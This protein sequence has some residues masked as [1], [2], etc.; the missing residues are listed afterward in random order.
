MTDAAQPDLIKIGSIGAPHALSG[1]VRVRTIDDP[2][3]LLGIK[4]VQIATRGWLTVKAWENHTAGLIVRLVGVTTKEA[5]DALRDLEI[6]ADR[7]ELRLEP[8]RFFYHDLIG[9]PVRT[10]DGSELGRVDDV[11]DSGAHDLLSIAVDGQNHLVPLQAPYVHV[12]EGFVEL[13]P[14]PGLLE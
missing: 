5:A 14:I 1:A 9:L 12:R 4:R 3:V 2:D 7:S 8:G 11:L 6:F 13:E 10:P